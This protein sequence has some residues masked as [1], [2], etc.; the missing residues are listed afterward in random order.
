GYGR[1]VLAPR[2]RV[3]GQ[4]ERHQEGTQVR[5]AEA[6]LAVGVR[7]ARDLG[8]GVAGAVDHDVLGGDD[9]VDCVPEGGDVEAP[10][11]LDE[12]HQVQS[13]EVAG[14]VVEAHVLT[15]RIGRGEGPGDR[16]S[17]K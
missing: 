10:V 13:G 3:V 5:V 12:L 16:A 8:R 2:V 7:G 15:A 11:R 14:A 9:D 17:V 6:E 4:A 1:G